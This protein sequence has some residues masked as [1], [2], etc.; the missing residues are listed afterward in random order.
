M[1]KV[2]VFDIE[3]DNLYDEVTTMHCAVFSS[4]DGKEVDEFVEGQWD[5][6]KKFMDSC[7]VLIAHNC[8]QYDFPV[9]EKLLGYVYQGKKVD[10]VLMSRLQNPNRPL[11]PTA[12]KD[13]DAMRAPHGLAA[14]GHRVGIAKPHIEAWMDMSEEILVRCR[15]DVR[16][17]VATYHELMAEGKGQNWKPAHLMTF[18]LWENLWK[19]EQAGWLV[20]ADYIRKSIRMLDGFINRIDR[21]LASYLPMTLEICE[22]KKDGEYNYVR[23]PFMKSGDYSA[24]VLKHFPEYE[25][26]NDPPVAAPFTRINY[27]PV[28][29]NSNDE[30]KKWLLQSGWIPKEWNLDS[31]GN[32]TSPKM[33]KDEEFEGVDGKM[34]RLIVKR[35]QSRH[36]RS[37]LEGWL[38]RIRPDG[39][40]PSRVTGLAD[41]RRAKHADIVNVPNA[42]AFFGKQMRRCFISRPGWS[43]VSA[44]AA[45]CQDRMMSERANDDAFTKMLLEGNKDDGTDSHTLARDAVNGVLAPRKI[46][47]I[48]RGK[49]KNFNFAWTFGASDNKLGK[50]CIA[51]KDVGGEIREALRE[52][53]P[54]KAALIDKVTAEWEGNAK[55]RVNRWGKKEYYNGWIKGLDGAP[56]YIASGHAVLVYAVQSDEAVYMSAVYNLAHKYLAKRFKWGE[57]YLVVCW[58]HDEVTVECRDEIKEEVAAI[59]ES[60]FAAATKY[61]KLKVPQIGEASIGKN[62]LEVH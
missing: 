15:T 34:G 9:M 5:D 48:T 35:V 47:T 2:R 7:D 49:A 52:V 37:Q 56:I 13:P 25:L 23:K 51:S 40:I 58:Y 59:L 16:I 46:H 39:R 53:F 38:K 42:E 62:W 57:D 32:P 21:V 22:T 26:M 6:M 29:L 33:S 55:V 36:R 10:T 60:A 50:M 31:E 8:I 11:P 17:N 12:Y 45:S 20:D 27:R 18:T 19:Q 30:T 61:F 1:T 24:S 3:A 44:D 28:D 43:L 41:T 4:L 14:W 54:A